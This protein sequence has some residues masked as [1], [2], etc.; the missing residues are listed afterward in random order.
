[1]NLIL[2]S[3][4]SGTRLWPLSNDVRSKQFI[5]LFRREDGE[6]ESML[7]NMYGH[8]RSV[9]PDAVVTVATSKMQ[10]AA[11]R[12]Q[13]GDDVGVS[14]EPCRRDTFPAI[15]LA[16][17]YLHD[18]Q[19]VSEDDAV[20]VCP[21][22]PYVGKEYFSALERLY[23]LAKSD[24]ASNLTLMG[25]SPTYPSDKYGYIIPEDKD[26]VS[27]V[28]MFKEKPDEKT[29]ESYIR[30]GALWNSGVFAFKISYL[31]EKAKDLLGTS[32]Y[33]ELYD[34]YDE[35][36]KISFDYA[37]SEK[38]KDISVLRFSGKWEDVGSWDSLVGVM[39][40]QIVGDAAMHEGC[41]NTK[42][43]N[44]LDIPVIAMGM[45]DT[46]ISASSQ[47]ILVSDV[48]VAS[49][50]KPYVEDLNQRVMF[51]D[52]SWGA[53]HILDVGE[54]SLTIKVTLKAEEHMR[55]HSHEHRD[56]V[57]VVCSGEGRVVVDGM[58]Q[59]VSAGDVVTMKAGCRHIIF[60]KTPMTLIEVQLGKDIRIEDKTV[61]DGS[62][63][64]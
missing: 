5:K 19:K 17:L 59:T 28:K 11:I 26:E 56:E 16:V 43:I 40:D 38:E 39:E 35:A 32:D 23:Q 53:F 24:D 57:W 51:G 14:V 18:V 33:V 27:R 30:E 46:V 10:A 31:M 1:M 3:G 34:G 61:Y 58:E 7:Q 63:Y 13:L 49:K 2:L 41:E 22:D 8:I 54:D 64:E 44:E 48:S 52:K 21:V 4:G 9:T 36:K 60:A 25:I 20:V 45:K 29:A 47:G 15:A 55:Y 42:I 12:N 50:I 6:Y 62:A 37:V